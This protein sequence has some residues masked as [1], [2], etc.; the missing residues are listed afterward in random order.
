MPK[1]FLTG[2]KG[3]IKSA[4]TLTPDQEELLG[5]IKEGITS[6]EG[7]LKDIFGEFNK[8]EFEKGVSEPALKNFQEKVLP[9]ILEKFAGQGFGSA[10]VNAATKAGGDLQSKLAELMYGAQQN[11]KQNRISGLNTAIGRQGVE[12]IYKPGTEGALQGL[13]KG[14]GQG[15]GNAIG[16]AIPGAGTGILNAAKSIIAG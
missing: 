16:G 9:G 10:N 5:L 7:P 2:T 1:G 15:A 6:G 3:K 14:I 12:N 4:S 13:V 8:E 11:Q